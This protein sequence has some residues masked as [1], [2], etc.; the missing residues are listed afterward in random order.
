[1]SEKYHPN[2]SRPE[3]E[4]ILAEEDTGVLCLSDGG[5]PYAVPV[6]YAWMNDRIIFHCATSGKKLD[7]M[8][9]NPQVC[10]VV[11]R[12]PDRAKPHHPEGECTYRFESVLCFGTAKV[13]ETPEERFDYLKEFKAF[14]DRRLGLP[15]EKNPVTEKAA[16]NC[17]C[18]VISINRMT[19]RKKGN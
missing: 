3:M 12:H 5:N 19:G 16:K 6:S 9:K 11:D 7:I 17:G 8:R 18:V 15:P 13:L 1:M 2:L 4:K 10:F 14:F